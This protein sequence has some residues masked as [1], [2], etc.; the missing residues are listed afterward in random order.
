MLPPGYQLS[1]QFFGDMFRNQNLIAITA[2][3]E[4]VPY[5]NDQR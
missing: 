1:K 4:D 3:I 2:V 5:I